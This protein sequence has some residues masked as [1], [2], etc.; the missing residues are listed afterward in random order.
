MSELAKTK[1][2][3]A[4]KIERLRFI[5]LMEE[6]KNIL[7]HEL[8]LV[9]EEI[10]NQK[11]P[12]FHIDRAIEYELKNE[13]LIMPLTRLFSTV[14]SKMGFIYYSQMESNLTP[15]MTLKIQSM[16]KEQQRREFNKRQ[17][18]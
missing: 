9:K 6:S 11:S 4:I 12:C 5:Q 3:N 1:R 17:L 18:N 16:N 10:L 13:T 8:D 2:D 15:E 14:R 7:P